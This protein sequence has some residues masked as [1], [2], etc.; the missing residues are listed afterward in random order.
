M[1]NN[2]ITATLTQ[3]EGVVKSMKDL[4]QVYWNAYSASAFILTNLIQT[5]TENLTL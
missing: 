5:P 3:L 1:S 4:T 2:L